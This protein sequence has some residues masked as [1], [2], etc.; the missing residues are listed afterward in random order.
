MR[1][2]LGLAAEIPVSRPHGVIEFPTW[3]P[4]ASGPVVRR[5]MT[6][7]GPDFKHRDPASRPLGETIAAPMNARTKSVLAAIM[8]LLA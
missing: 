5:P 2:K 6:F 7:C 3:R 8:R 1:S 4:G